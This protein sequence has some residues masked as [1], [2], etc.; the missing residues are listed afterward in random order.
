MN[1]NSKFERIKLQHLDSLELFSTSNS[2]QDFPLHYHENFCISIIEKGAFVEN[3]KI[4]LQHS[5][6]IS[7]PLEVHKNSAFQNLDYSIKTLYVSK[8]IFKFALAKTGK[9]QID[10]NFLIQNLITDSFL[11]DKINQLANHITSQEN[12][13][14]V[15]FEREFI[16]LIQRIGQFE[17]TKANTEFNNLVKPTWLEEVKQYVSLYLDQKINLE[18]LASKTKLDKF[19]FIRA[20]KKH[21]GLTPFQYILLS[22]IALTKKLLQEGNSLIETAL[23]AGFYDQSNF[24]KY[25]KNYVGVTPRNYQQ[26]F[27]IIQE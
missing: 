23:D 27:N 16:Q 12:N 20:F 22:R 9:N 15:N 3:N 11:S 25:F 1:N 26:S 2:N 10:D 17:S 18:T 6:L 21:T 5:V 19:Q 14:D 24:A 8:D 13:F 4:A 7:N